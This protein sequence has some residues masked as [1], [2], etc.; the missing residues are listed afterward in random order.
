MKARRVKGLGG[1]VVFGL[2]VGAGMSRAQTAQEK[3][4]AGQETQA[5]VVAIR[6]VSEDGRVLSESPKNVS[7]EIGKPLDRAKVAESLRALYRTGNYAD[8]RAESLAVG[9]GLQLEFIAREN[10]FF[11][12]L[13]IEGLAAPPT[14]A[15]A[16]AAMQMA[17]GM[18]YRQQILDESLERLRE[19]L[20]EEGLYTAEVFAQT[21][22][23]PEQ[24]Q[25]DV[26]VHV[27]PGKTGEG[28][29]DTSDKW[30]GISRCRDSCQ[31]EDEARQGVDGGTVAARDGTHPKIFGEEGPSKRAG[32]GAARRL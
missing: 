29:S 14:E 3:P 15:S 21:A 7:V 6:I 24:H 28:G 19:V 18:P 20:K 9:G 22:P 13:K 8:L 1:I 4:P 12:Q 25:M 16:A 2:L 27:K 17:L 32:G 30:D 10:L 5:V 23:H 11:N 31:A 26:I